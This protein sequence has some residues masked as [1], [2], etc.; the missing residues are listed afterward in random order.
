M[1][2]RLKKLYC[3]HIGFQYMFIAVRDIHACCLAAPAGL[4]PLAQARCLFP[5]C[6]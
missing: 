4:V 2:D 5:G 1:I 6:P 3:H